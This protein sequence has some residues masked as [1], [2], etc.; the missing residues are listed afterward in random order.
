MDILIARPY[1]D[2]KQ[3][4]ELFEAS[5][6]S[7]GIL[8]SIKIVHKKINL[9]I[10]NFTDFAFT[11]KYAVESLFRQYLPATFVDKSIYSVGATTA[12]YLRNFSLN[13]KYPNEYNSR[14]LFKLISEQSL[15]DRKFAIFSGVDGNDYLEKEIN[16]H[17]ICQKFETYE[18][19]FESKEFLHTKYLKLWRGKQPKFVITTSIDVFKSLNRIFEKIPAPNDSIVTITSTKMLKFVYS[20]GFYKT[21]E[22]ENPSNEHIC[23]KILQHI[24]ANDYVSREK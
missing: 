2:A 6:L 8:P 10:E 1:D 18:R 5:G 22:L 23:A 13:A 11:S 19:A 15:S 24:E 3:L 4:A 20:Q 16:K 21:L 17:T 12:N 14:E 7:V 9:K